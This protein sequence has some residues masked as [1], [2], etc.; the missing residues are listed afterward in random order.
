MTERNIFAP[1]ATPRVFC[2][3]A[4]ELRAQERDAMR[5]A[6]ICDDLADGTLDAQSEL[7]RARAENW[8][9]TAGELRWRAAQIEAAA[10]GRFE[11]IET[12][13]AIDAHRHREAIRAVLVTV[14]ICAVLLWSCTPLVH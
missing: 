10:C 4:Q 11:H 5:H 6:A 14:G 7:W 3:K 1:M 12:Q 2:A 9:A 8:R 13:A